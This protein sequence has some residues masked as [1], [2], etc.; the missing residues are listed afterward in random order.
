[1]ITIFRIKRLQGKTVEKCDLR[2]QIEAVIEEKKELI[3]ELEM[4]LFLCGSEDVTKADLLT[5]CGNMQKEIQDDKW[6][7]YKLEKM[8]VRTFRQ[9]R[10]T[11]KARRRIVQQLREYLQG[12][13]VI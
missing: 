3:E 10:E 4:L 6:T 12:K 9:R 1:M 13:G 2:E 5:V 8:F 11:W 7:N